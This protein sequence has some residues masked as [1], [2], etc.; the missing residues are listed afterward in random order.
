MSNIGV[1]WHWDLV[2]LGRA[3]KIQRYV[4]VKLTSIINVDPIFIFNQN[5]TSV[6][7]HPNIT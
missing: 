5:A 3:T 6:W 7:R 2:F 1:S 4:T